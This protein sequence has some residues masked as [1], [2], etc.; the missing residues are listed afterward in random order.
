[1]YAAAAGPCASSL[2]TARWKTF[3]P[4]VL[5]DGRVADGVISGIPA[6]SK[7]GSAASDSPENGGPTMPR[8]LVSV[9]RLRASPGATAGSPCESNFLILMQSAPFLLLYWST[10]SSAPCSMFTPRFADEPVSAPKYA[11]L[12]PQFLPLDEPV[13]LLLLLHAAAPARSAK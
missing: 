13:V 12:Y 10:A 9:T 11:I 3:Q 5:S 1:M 7:I 2:A 8:I 6:E 4:W